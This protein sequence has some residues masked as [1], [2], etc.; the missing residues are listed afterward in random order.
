MK[1]SDMP[2]SAI[3]D[4][5]VVGAGP[6]GAS[7]AAAAARPNLQ[8]LM[9]ERRAVVGLPVQCAEYIPALL[10]GELNIGR[11]YLVQPVRGMKTF[12]A[13]REVKETLSPGFI[14]NREQFDQTLVQAACDSGAHLMLNTK[15]VSQ[16]GDDVI[17]KPKGRPPL[18]IKAKIIIGADGPLSTVAEWIGAAHH[19]LIRAIQIRVPL[20]HRL[21]F[22]EVYFSKDFY[23]GYAWLFPKGDQ[24][25]LGLGIKKKGRRPPPLGRLLEYFTSQCSRAGKIVA[26]PSGRITGWIPAGPVSKIVHGNVLLAGDAAGHTHPITGAGI[27]PAVAAGRMAGTWAAR[28]IQEKNLQVLS[29]YESEYRNLFG[30]SMQRAVSRRQQMESRWDD[31]DNILKNCWVAFKEYYAGT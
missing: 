11:K 9:I 12:L 2:S 24:A 3:C 20:K 29:G 1:S 25:N 15:A 4:I 23:G 21:E 8:V 14:I 13:G 31:L 10:V 30:D 5:L 19:D 16:N 6:A 18:K 26:N 7:A 28:A 27:F 22:T 17:I